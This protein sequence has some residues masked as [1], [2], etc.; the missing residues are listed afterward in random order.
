MVLFQI[1]SHSAEFNSEVLLILLIH[2]W[3]LEGQLLKKKYSVPV[4]SFRKHYYKITDE[5]FKAKDSFFHNLKLGLLY[6]Q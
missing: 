6:N 1:R 4:K 5:F 3:L 2:C